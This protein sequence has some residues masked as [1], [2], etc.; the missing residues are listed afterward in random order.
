MSNKQKA[1]TALA[2]TSII[3]GTTW[4]AMKF[5]VKNM[6][7]LEL[8]SIRQFLAASIFIIFFLIKKEKLPTQ[9]QFI[10]LFFLGVLTFV[11]S[12]GVSTWSLKYIPSGLGALIGA[13]YPLCVVLIEYFFYQNKNITWLSVVGIALGICGMIIVF[14]DNAF[15]NHPK[16]YGIGILLAFIA[17]FSWSWATI[18]IGKKTVKINAY[19]SMGW[20]ML[21]SSFLLAGI[22]FFSNNYLPLIQIPAV[23]WI[24]IFYLIIMG[25]VVAVIAFVYS[26]HHL[27][28][29][30][31]SLYAYINPLVAI[32]IGTFLL[33]EHL[34]FKIILGTLITLMGV[35]LVNKSLKKG[36]MSEVPDAESI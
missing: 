1:Y 5:G 36:R 32:F 11:L 12:N 31:A 8:A 33:D 9:Q 27:P 24:A 4:V 17:M 6:P 14:Y 7:P 34:T 18:F 15:A 23:S 25:S 21:F 20:Q 13:L 10:Q 35:Y 3:W 22:T 28:T 26:M 29:A 16:G 19:F 2:A 30:I